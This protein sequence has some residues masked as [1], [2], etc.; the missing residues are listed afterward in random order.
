MSK[1]Q[2]LSAPAKTWTSLTG[3]RST[4]G[5]CALA[6]NGKSA[7]TAARTGTMTLRRAVISGLLRE[8]RNLADNP[9][10]V[11][12]RWHGGR[13]RA[14]AKRGRSRSRRRRLVRRE[15][16]RGALVAQRH[17]RLV[18]HLRGRRRPLPGLRDEHP[19]AE[20]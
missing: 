4:V 6:A 5:G 13:S 12:R 7:A 8:R 18:V 16:A 17:V 14:Y 1:G 19:G 15:R 11:T 20:S 2:G 10:A 3:T 9:I